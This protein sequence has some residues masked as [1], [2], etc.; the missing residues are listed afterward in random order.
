MNGLK[1]I[2][3]R[4]NVT[5]EELASKIGVLPKLIRFWEI[6]SDCITDKRKK[7]LATYFGIE[8]K[9]FG[10]ISEG[11]KEYL[12][13]KAMF[14]YITNG[15]EIF[16]YKRDS[17]S[18]ELD[19]DKM[20]FLSDRKISIDEEYNLALKRKENV[21]S[22]I[23]KI[24]DRNNSDDYVHDKIMSINRGCNMYDMVNAL[25]EA[26]QKQK[27]YLKVPF[28]YEIINV[29][30]AM[31]VAYGLLDEEDLNKSS[32]IQ[33]F[34][35]EDLEWISSISKLILEHWNA[36]KLYCEQQ[37][38]EAYSSKSVDDIGER[39]AVDDSSCIEEQIQSAEE[40]HRKRRIEEK[41]RKYGSVVY[42]SE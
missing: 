8:E 13:D 41:G 14:K 19:R 24:I 3:N 15:R 27:R 25:M 18:S 30:T 21:L 40:L 10:D 39:K 26:V 20:F 4:C 5:I 29:Y 22:K 9:Y 35:G 28:R 11:D 38:D 12:I 16:L 6:D 37:R 17:S 7:E 1:Y 42:I 23:G 33:G 32:D 34:Y 2:R 31:L 36:K